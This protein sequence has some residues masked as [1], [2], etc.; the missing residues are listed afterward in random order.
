MLLCDACEVQE[1]EVLIRGE[2]VTAYC[3]CC[4]G[5]SDE[6]TTTYGGE[7]HDDVLRPDP[8]KALTT[9]WKGSI[10][11]L[12]AAKEIIAQSKPRSTE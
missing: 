9:A 1:D 5:D 4:D 10:D 11:S 2:H 6:T 7:A 3:T 12:G 8:A